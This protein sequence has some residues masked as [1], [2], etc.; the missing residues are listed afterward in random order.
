MPY[1]NTTASVIVISQTSASAVG[2]Q[3]PFIER[4]ISGSNLFLVTDANG[5]LT[6]ST[7][8]P[9]GS[10]TNLTVTGA[11]TASIIS[12]STAITAAAIT[13]GPITA[14]NLSASGT[15]T[16]NIAN[17]T[18]VLSASGGITASN[19]FDA[20]TLTVLGNS[21]L[22][23][24]TASNISASG[25]LSASSIS[26]T[27]SIT[28]NGTLTVLG[29]TTL[30]N[31]ITDITTVTGSLRISGSITGSL[32]GTASHAN[33][34]DYLYTDI[35]NNVVSVGRNTGVNNGP[36][37]IPD[38]TLV[39]I[40]AGQSL[41]SGNSST[42]IG[43]SAGLGIITG[44]STTIVGGYAGPQTTATQL[45]DSI[46]IGNNAGQNAFTGSTSILIGNNTDAS[47][48][49][50]N[51]SGSILIGYDIQAST[52][53]TMILGGSNITTTI[54]RGNITASGNISASIISG[55]VLVGPLT[56]SVFGTASWAHSASNAVRAQTASFLPVGTYNITSSWSTNAVTASSLV[57]ANS[58]N[59][60]NL[61]ASSI[62]TEYISVRSGSQEGE[63]VL[64]G[65]TTSLSSENP[66]V[67]NLGGTYSDTEGLRPKLKLYDD[68]NTNNTIGIGVSYDNQINTIVSDYIVPTTSSHVF[69]IG[70]TKPVTIKTGSVVIASA[71]LTAS[72][73]ISASGTIIASSFTGSFSGSI[74]NA[75]SATTAS[76]V[77]VTDTSTGTGPYYVA[78]VDGTSG[79]RAVR[80]DSATLTW[81]STNN[82]LSSSGNFVGVN[83]TASR[84]TATG[85]AGSNTAV[86]GQS[87]IT[88]N[89]IG[90]SGNSYFNGDV[91]IGT[92]LTVGSNISGS[93][94]LWLAGNTTLAGNS[95]TV[96]HTGTG[97]LTISSTGGSVVVEGSTFNANDLTVPGDV[98]INGGD[99]TTTAATFN[100][101]T[102]SATTVNFAQSATA[103][104]VGATG[105]TTTFTG[106]VAI[107]GGDLTT[108]AATFN[109]LAGNTNTT[110]I[111][112]F[113]TPTVAGT[114]NIRSVKDATALNDA[115]VVLNGG[116][117][118]TKSLI[119]GG[120]M[121]LYGDLTLFGTGSIVNISSSTIIL[122]DN[123]IQLNTWNSAGTAQRYGGIDVVDS[124]S[125]T[126]VTS[127]L[128]WDSLN[129]YWLLQTNNTG[130]PVTQS[131]AIILQGPTSS[132]GSEF[133]LT[134][135]NFLKVQTREGNMITSSLSEV[136][137]ELRYAGTISASVVSGST[138][139]GQTGSFINLAI[140]TGS[141]PGSG[142]QVPAHPTASGLSGQIEVDNNF[143]YV[144]TN[145][146]WKRVP[147]SVWSL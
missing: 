145:S 105:S 125:T 52:P 90:V 100:L 123:R 20:G 108:T 23:N 92:T 60:T 9:G 38:T 84:V 8:I 111:N 16:L 63:A 43:I 88:S 132:F 6:G 3:F 119:V 89:G 124:G 76:T 53:N 144:Y 33:F 91:G 143:I 85:G 112:M 10:F 83:Y 58:Y 139:F 65:R 94:N 59:I 44:S 101:V 5:L 21:I 122:G 66:I 77:L 12:A 103:I 31:Q 28:N 71:N 47:S 109:L 62:K 32:T 118:I 51:I 39:G 14:S 140:L 99:L 82:T 36:S 129:N 37:N 73:N 116:M 57:T 114:L 27:T 131:S 19:I 137:N 29:N 1:P 4:Q 146:S 115:A 11:L 110:T 46:F 55:S 141:A 18:G 34:V 61:T 42:L 49:T 78:F 136:G 95:A 25:F 45:V 86:S 117:S 17:I 64:F 35:T 26:V 79:P 104:S 87:I 147:L 134:V 15:T 102:G 133:L 41:A 54:I 98:A 97:N 130:S 106:D 127:S 75:V 69:W 56:G 7:S 93:S 81:D 30:G 121:T 68:T 126:N 48:S 74:N 128:L 13:S 120:N 135:N 113:A 67:V 2:G 50:S 107:N 80:T 96:T 142:T 24:I 70:S 72:G 40:Y 22:A 138:I